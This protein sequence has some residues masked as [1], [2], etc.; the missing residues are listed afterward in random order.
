MPS[1]VL[2]QPGAGGRNCPRAVPPFTAVQYQRHRMRGSDRI[3]AT[4]LTLFPL[5]SHNH[6]VVTLTRHSGSDWLSDSKTPLCGAAVICHV[7]TR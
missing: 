6:A 4:I 5:L 7:D 1:S 3:C 2:R